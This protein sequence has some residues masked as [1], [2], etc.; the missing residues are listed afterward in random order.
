ELGRVGG[1]Q[2]SIVTRSGTNTYHGTLFEYFRDDA[3]DSADYFVVRQG[4][5]KPKERQHDVGGT[6]GG[7][8]ERDRTFMFVSYEGLGLDQPRSAVTEVPSITSRGAAPSALQPILAAFPLPNGPETANGFAQFSASYSDP[9]RLNATSVRVDH[10]LAPSLTLF[11][12]YNYAPSS[13]SSRLGSFGVA[14]ISTLGF[15]ED[16]LQTLTLGSTWILTA[17]VSNDLRFN[18]SRNT[19]N[20]YQ[21][22]DGFG[23]SVVPPAAVLHPSFAPGPS[24]YQF[25][26]GGLD[27]T[28]T[29]GLNSNNTQRQ[30][31]IVDSLL[32][33]KPR[34]QIKVGVDLRRLLPVYDPVAYAQAYVFSSATGALTGTAPLMVVGSFPRTNEFS[35]A[36]NLSTF[37]QDTW[38]MTP[39]LSLTYGLRWELNP[40]PG[41][42]G[43]SSGSLTL[44]SA[45]PSTLALA[46]PGAPMYQTTYDKFAPRV[47][48]S[49]AL[50]ETTAGPG[51]VVRGGW[52]D[53]DARGSN[54]VMENLG[55]SFPFIARRIL[56]N[57]ALPAAQ[58]LLT[59]PTIPPGAAADFLTAADPTLKLPYTNEW[60]AAV[61]QA[62]GDH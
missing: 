3:L 62:V 16:S 21:A 32:I 37:G 33:P 38:T 46:A 5:S 15:L 49:Y 31:N 12:R 52:G 22:L 13:A 9:S 28:F 58:T 44:A 20:N 41:L 61:E 48:A 7:P 35:H 42:S 43:S 57:V 53:F 23:G 45:N 36:T 1:G 25:L 19:G 39:R 47:G 17:S 24:A 60:N 6:F 4:L 51:A 2:V 30:L 29:D 26:L 8:I 18:W 59:P 50:H 40:P 27:A 10:T 54:S 11:G 14:S 55:A 56:T 34:H